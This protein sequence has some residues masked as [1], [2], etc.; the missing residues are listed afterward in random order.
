MAIKRT[1]KPPAE[2]R[3]PI[4]KRQPKVA[5]PPEEVR[6]I[7]RVPTARDRRPLTNRFG[8]TLP[9]SAARSEEQQT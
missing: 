5:P 2:T 9:Q 4:I 1:P 8:D 3:R 7:R 6:A